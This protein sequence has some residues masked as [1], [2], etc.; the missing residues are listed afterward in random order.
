M[1]RYCGF[2]DEDILS[3]GEI[4]ERW[5]MAAATLVMLPII[6]LFFMFQRYFMEG[7][8]ITGIK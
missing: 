6:V 7:I 1:E 3:C 2:N 4:D 5:K 8:T